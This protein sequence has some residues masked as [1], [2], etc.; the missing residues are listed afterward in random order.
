LKSK[1]GHGGDKYT[2]FAPDVLWVAFSIPPGIS[3]NNITR[4]IPCIQKCLNHSRSNV[5][6]A[7]QEENKSR[8]LP[9]HLLFY[10]NYFLTLKCT[11]NYTYY[12]VVLLV[13]YSPR[14]ASNIL[15]K[16]LSLQG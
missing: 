6:Q 7:D 9:P 15:I 1:P 16:L 4:E 13:A 14:F 10:R 3:Y 11:Q 8:V 12:A 5:L 2:D